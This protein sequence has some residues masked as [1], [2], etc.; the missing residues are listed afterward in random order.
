M[1]IATLLLL[2]GALGGCATAP[3][4]EPPEALP[5][6]A[7]QAPPR[8][9]NGAIFQAGYDVRLYED[10]T[11]RRVGDIVTVVLE[12]ETDASKEAETN[13]DKDSSLS[14]PVPT[15]L[16]QVPTYR[17]EPISFEVD[18]EREFE[19]SGDSSQSNELSGTL[20]ATVIRV[21]PNG[22]LVIQGQKRLTLN[23]GDEYV[24]ITGVVRPED[25]G[26]DNTV[27]STRVASARISYTG[28]GALA[29]SNA[30]GWLSRLFNSAL[31][32]F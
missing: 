22:N 9:T 28:T 14:M 11:A 12:E 2:A 3:R 29:D 1:R 23:Q 4:V 18:T 27:S 6:P 26:A 31:W 25:V 8:E 10:R 32:P 24:T 30:M 7:L 13:I 21:E 17:G 20:S 16:G 5:Q 19:G 15:L